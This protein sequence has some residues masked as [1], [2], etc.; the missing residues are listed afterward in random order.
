MANR[1]VFSILNRAPYYIEYQTEFQFFSGFAEVQKRRSIES[2]H[3]SYKEHHP[4]DNV[5]EIS[6]KSPDIIGVRLSAFNLM[7]KLP[8]G[9][10]CSLESAFQSSKVFENGG[11]YIDLLLCAPW[12]VKKDPRIRNSGAV[13]AFSFN[14]HIFK[15]EPKTFFYDWLYITTVWQDFSLRQAILRYSAFTDIEFNPKKSINCQ[16]RSAAIFVSL[17]KSGN[18]LQALSSP[19]SFLNIVYE[20]NMQNEQQSLFISDFYSSM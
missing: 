11:P 18:L 12:E 1:P 3:A 13:T 8:E 5:L 14:G 4:D 16:A 10:M 15:T 19:E 9:R 2:L 6:T 20:S 7:V 17:E